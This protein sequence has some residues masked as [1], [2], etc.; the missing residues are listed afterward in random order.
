MSETKS[1]N[2]AS[3]KLSLICTKFEYSS[4]EGALIMVNF[5]FFLLFLI[6]VIAVV[7][8]KLK[9][10]NR[11]L[12]RNNVGK[13]K[14]KNFLACTKCDIDNCTRLFDRDNAKDKVSW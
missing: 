10:N 6:M 13:F 8:E 9:L 7:G 4:E 12:D 2:E 1:V 11:S 14:K 5:N 3:L